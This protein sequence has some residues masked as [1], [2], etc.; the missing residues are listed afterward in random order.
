MTKMG[1]QGLFTNPS[2]LFALYL[3]L[4]GLCALCGKSFLS[5]FLEKLAQNLPAVFL[6]NTPRNFHPMILAG[7]FQ[8]K[9]KRPDCAPL[10]IFRPKDQPFNPRLEKRSGTH[11]AGLEGD[12]KGAS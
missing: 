11:G 12:I 9:V 7:I 5:S 3:I 8:Q 1:Q 6:K 4:C 2:K 10:R